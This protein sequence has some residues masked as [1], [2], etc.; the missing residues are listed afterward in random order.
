MLNNQ[1][2]TYRPFIV[3]LTVPT[4]QAYSC[5]YVIHSNKNIKKR[6][7]VTGWPISHY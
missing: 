4:K 1:F 2:L 3:V 7:W 5:L 6:K